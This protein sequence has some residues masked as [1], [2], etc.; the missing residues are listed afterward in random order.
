[1]KK[2]QGLAYI[3]QLCC[4]GLGEASVI[5]E[6]LRAIRAVIPSVTNVFQRFDKDFFPKYIIPEFVVP[7][8][9]DIFLKENRRMCTPEIAGNM[10]RWH[11]CYRV[12][13]DARLLSDHIYSSDL[14]HLVWRP[15]E[16]HHML[17]GVVTKGASGSS[18]LMVSRP[19]SQPE[20]DASDK[21][22]FERLLPYVEYALQTRKTA[23]TKYADQ[24]ESGLFVM[25]SQGKLVFASEAARKLLALIRYPIYPIGAGVALREV[26]IPPALGQLCRHLDGI[27]RG[28][29][30]PPPILTHGNPRGRFVFRAH[31][32]DP[33][34]REPG[35]LIGVTVEHREPAVL[36]LLRAMKDLP[37]SPVQREV[38]L[39]LAQNHTQD[40][41][42][43][44][45][46]IKP[47]TVKDHVRKI[48]DKLGVCRREE[49][50][51]R[52]IPKA[53]GLH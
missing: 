36:R 15:Y 33:V 12:M 6:L 40:S 43:Q 38:C 52:L 31:W 24:G 51:G 50:V 8:A 4:L 3:R 47:T 16:F 28:R 46:G 9:L 27:F 44:R 29:D 37:L 25:D 23:E 20:F 1:M 18:F 22:L 45:L 42:G 41:I 48:Y 2:K 13:S 17:Q 11:G 7:E 10:H 5:P 39:L 21:R 34:N 53:E 26:S 14:Y 30:A 19:R 49:L 32:L 35:S